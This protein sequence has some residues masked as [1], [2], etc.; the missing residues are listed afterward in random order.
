MCLA[1]ELVRDQT[2][3]DDSDPKS[4]LISEAGYVHAR[5]LIEFLF[6]YS[7]GPTP[8]EIE[9]GIKPGPRAI[10]Y[11]DNRSWGIRSRKRDF[12]VLLGGLDVKTIKT[13]IDRRVLHVALDRDEIPRIDF[14]ELIDA[15]KTSWGFF[16]QGLEAPWKAKFE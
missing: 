6:F 7:N 16:T 12:E 9:R 1:H 2:F 5:N 10:W 14:F 3:G 15:L 11:S 4:W 13:R 8:E